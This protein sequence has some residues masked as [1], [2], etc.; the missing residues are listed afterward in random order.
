MQQVILIVS[1]K[2][3]FGVDYFREPLAVFLVIVA[4]ALWVSWDGEF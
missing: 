1:G 4:F 3:L 2:V